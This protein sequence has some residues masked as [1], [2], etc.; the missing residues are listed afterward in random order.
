MQ[1]QRINRLSTSSSTNATQQRSINQRHHST[2]TTHASLTSLTL[3][4]K[5]TLKR[6]HLYMY[7]QTRFDEMTCKMHMKAMTHDLLI[8]YTCVTQRTAKSERE[9]RNAI[10]TN[11]NNNNNKNNKN[12]QI[13]KC[14][15]ISN[16][17]KFCTGV[18]RRF[19]TKNLQV[20]AR[21]SNV[22]SAQQ[23]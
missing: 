4:R 13:T 5:Q 22:H 15:S 7:S 14:H 1:R 3:Y 12:H 18:L 11:S 20:S 10:A 23:R 19:F 21:I 17:P 6:V 8:L 16:S 2:S 9:F